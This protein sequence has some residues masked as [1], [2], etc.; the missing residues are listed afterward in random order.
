MK[1]HP[2]TVYFGHRWFEQQ[3]YSGCFVYVG[4]APLRFERAQN[5]SGFIVRP[6][7]GYSGAGPSVL[8]LALLLD[9][10]GDVQRSLA[11]YRWFRWAVVTCWTGDKWSITAAEI[12]AWLDQFDRECHAEQLRADDAHVRPSPHFAVVNGGA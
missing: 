9:A 4:G 12:G 7:W 11:A 5:L 3:V 6:E 10:T 2:E 8:A 1:R